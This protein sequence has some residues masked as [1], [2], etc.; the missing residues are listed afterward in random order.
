MPNKILLA[1]RMLLPTL[2]F[3]LEI[4]HPYSMCGKAIREKLA[5]EFLIDSIYLN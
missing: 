5:R 3:D 2:R 1:E 4:F